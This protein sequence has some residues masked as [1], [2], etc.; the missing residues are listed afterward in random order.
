MCNRG[1]VL[2]F[3]ALVFAAEPA[4]GQTVAELRE[5][6]RAMQARRTASFER[7]GQAEVDAQGVTDTSM[8]LQDAM[9]HFRAADVSSRDRASIV[10]AFDDAAN[11]L[12]SAFGADG[13]SL[14]AGDNWRISITSWGNGV[15]R[16]SIS[17]V[18]A[19]ARYG[20]VVPLPLRSQALSELLVGRATTALAA[21]S[22]SVSEWVGHRFSIDDAQRT[23]Y[24]AY[25][26][27]V[28]HASD[29]GRRCARGVVADCAQNH[30]IAVAQSMLRYAI[31]RD[32]PTM[33]RSLKNTPE[34][35]PTPLAMIAA[36]LG[37]SQDE[38]LTQWH[39]HI[40]KSGATRAAGHAGLLFT[41]LAWCALFAALAARRRP[42]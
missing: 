8:I 29:A 14:L 25:R 7:I 12:R 26:Q 23:H 21:R 18:S 41:S 27:L 11:E 17:L 37:E 6:A 5:Q 35:S 40:S 15:P 4:F 39:A 1:V 38:F 28:L 32:G 42:Q 22:P 34:A 9:V 16:A 36:A 19:S 30:G 31:E 13:A 20:S 24:F 2:A 3:A 10:R 33:L